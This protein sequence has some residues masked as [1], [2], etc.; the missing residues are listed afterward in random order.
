MAY[1]V[2]VFASILLIFGICWVVFI[3][4]WGLW[5]ARNMRS[6]EK[7]VLF[8][9]SPAGRVAIWVMRMSGFLYIL[10]ALY[11]FIALLAPALLERVPFYAIA[12]LIS[13]P[14]LARVILGRVVSVLARKPS[15]HSKVDGNGE[16][17]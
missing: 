12:I 2:A 17:G 15:S 4:K 14:I 11:L 5:F 6:Q 13:L 1:F 16:R 9:S 8:L 10:L 3:H 7:A